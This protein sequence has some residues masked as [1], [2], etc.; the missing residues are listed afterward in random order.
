MNEIDAG[1]ISFYTIQMVG[2]AATSEIRGMAVYAFM[3]FYK[4][5]KKAHIV[6]NQLSP[7]RNRERVINCFASN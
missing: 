3:L 5:Y 7:H 2:L 4:G 6:A 1:S